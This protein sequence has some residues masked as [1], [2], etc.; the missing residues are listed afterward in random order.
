LATRRREAD[1]RRC[2]PGWRWLCVAPSS[3][4]PGEHS[5]E[6]FG[7]VLVGPIQGLARAG[8]W[9]PI[10]EAAMI[11]QPSRNRGPGLLKGWTRAS[12]VRRHHSIPLVDADLI[13]EALGLAGVGHQSVNARVLERPSCWTRQ[14]RLRSR[15]TAA[16]GCGRRLSD[17]AVSGLTVVHSAS[18]AEGPATDEHPFTE[19]AITPHPPPV[20]GTTLSEL[21]VWARNQDN[22]ERHEHGF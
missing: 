8:Q 16:P 21:S 2:G 9:V 14:L 5:V 11:W 19:S 15:C 10:V 20:D 17:R 3:E 18:L 22:G 4:F 12:Y 1:Q 13:L 6:L 7:S